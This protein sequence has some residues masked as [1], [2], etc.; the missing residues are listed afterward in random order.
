MLNQNF[1][2]YIKGGIY[3]DLLISMHNYLQSILKYDQNYASGGNEKSTIEFEYPNLQFYTKTLESAPN[4]NF[5]SASIQSSLKFK[6]Y[7][8]PE[9][10]LSKSSS[11]SS[12][13]LAFISLNSASTNLPNS[14]LVEQQQQQQNQQFSNMAG[15]KVKRTSLSSST[16]LISSFKYR[17][18]SNVFMFSQETTTTI[19][20]SINDVNGEHLVVEFF[21][22]NN[23]DTIYD[24]KHNSI[25]YRQLKTVKS[26]YSCV[27]M[28][29]K[30]RTWTMRGARVIAYDPIGNVVKCAYDLRLMRSGG[31]GGEGGIFAVITPQGTFAGNN[32][33]PINFSIVFRVLMP[34]ALGLLI[35]TMFILVLFRVRT[36]ILNKMSS[37]WIDE[38]NLYLD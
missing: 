16:W 7:F 28:N 35:F 8:T 36:Y 22:S 9:P 34:L 37:I 3:T 31:D 38:F 4:A 1:I 33:A 29:L 30:L 5:Y 17:V 23:F 21:L 18:V 14:L 20:T 11:T 24:A 26:D 6:L 10:N 25:Q 19:T 2:F 12:S 13:K 32:S 27:S 15:K